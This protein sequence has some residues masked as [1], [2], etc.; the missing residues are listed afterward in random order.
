VPCVGTP[1]F[2]GGGTLFLGVSAPAETVFFNVVVGFGAGVRVGLF[3]AHGDGEADGDGGSGDG[4]SARLAAG[5]A[6]EAVFGVCVGGLA[7]AAV[8]TSSSSPAT[9]TGYDLT[10]TAPPLLADRVAA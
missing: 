10:R 5:D 1:S 2:V 3:A 9:T 6:A 8:P 4:E 7:H